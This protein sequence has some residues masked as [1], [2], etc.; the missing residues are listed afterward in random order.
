MLPPKYLFSITHRFGAS[1]RNVFQWPAAM[2][3]LKLHRTIAWCIIA[4]N[5]ASCPS[6]PNVRNVYD[7]PIALASSVA[8]CIQRLCSSLHLQLH[9]HSFVPFCRQLATY[10]SLFFCLSCSF[11]M[12]QSSRWWSRDFMSRDIYGGKDGV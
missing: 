12:S 10:T 4:T 5:A 9:H 3:T 8:S 11:S 2:V 7:F 6:T 1:G